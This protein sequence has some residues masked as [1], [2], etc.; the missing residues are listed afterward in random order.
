MGFERV[1]GK[2][3]RVERGPLMSDLDRLLILLGRLGDRRAVPVIVEKTRLLT[4]DDDFSHHRAVAVALETL[5]DR[6]AA[7]PLA[8][9]LLKPGMS[10][11][12]HSS[13]E[14]A[15][16][17]ETRKDDDATQ[18]HRTRSRRESLSELMLA[19]ALYRCGDHEGL[20]EKTLRGYAEDLRGHLAR[21]AQAVLDAYKPGVPAARSGAETSR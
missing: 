11:H 20:G 6:S 14:L 7:K 16:N 10:G 19:R 12:V 21:H 3:R 5:G 4:A 2:L 1:D 13:I 15:R 17:I 18:Y 9:L 8:E